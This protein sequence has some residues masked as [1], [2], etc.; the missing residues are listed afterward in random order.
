MAGSVCDRC[1]QL[2]FKGVFKVWH[3]RLVRVGEECAKAIDEEKAFFKEMQS[4]GVGRDA[5][6]SQRGNERK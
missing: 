5:P 3:G 1:G 4:R 6:A 2:T